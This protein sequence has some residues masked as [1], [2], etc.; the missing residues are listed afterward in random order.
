MT[1]K[2]TAENYVFNV[3]L[4]KNM[5]ASHVATITIIDKNGREIPKGLNCLQFLVDKWDWFRDTE[6]VKQVSM[7]A[8]KHTTDVADEIP[9]PEKEHKPKKSS[10]VKISTEI[11]VDE[12]Q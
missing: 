4:Y 1:S 6:I 11:K 7:N 12:F 9:K 2:I 10:T 5:L 8:K 3:G